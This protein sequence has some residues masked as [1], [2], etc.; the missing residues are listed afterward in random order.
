MV[1][2]VSRFKHAGGVA[3]VPAALSWGGGGN[4]AGAGVGTDEGPCA[5]DALTPRKTA[6]GGGGSTGAVGIRSHCG[7]LGSGESLVEW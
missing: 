2:W 4:S 3:R 1:D 6:A 7:R 5:E